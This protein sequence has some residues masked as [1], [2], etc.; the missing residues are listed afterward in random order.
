MGGFRKR[1]AK[2][3]VA[4]GL[5]LEGPSD[6]DADVDSLLFRDRRKFCAKRPEVQSCHLLIKLFGQQIDVVLVDLGF[7]L[8]FRMAS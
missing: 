2:C 7:L 5:Q 3:S 1:H 6:L 4:V 8:F